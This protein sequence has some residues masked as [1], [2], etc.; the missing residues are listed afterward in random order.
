MRL[1]SLIFS[2]IFFIFFNLS[3]SEFSLEE[4][5]QFLKEGLVSK[6]EYDVLKDEILEIGKYNSAYLYEI[7]INNILKN[8]TFKAEIK[9][10]KVYFPLLDF[11]SIIN[12]VDYE[13]KNRELKAFLGERLLELKINLNN[14]K[15]KLDDKKISFTDEVYM[16]N[17]EIYIESKLFQELLA[18]EFEEDGSRFKIKILLKFKTPYEIKNQ[19]DNRFNRFQEEKNKNILLYTHQKKIFDLGYLRTKLD[20]SYYKKEKKGEWNSSLE[21]QGG[22]LYG[23]LTSSYNLREGELG[24]V[25]INYPEIYKGHSLEVGSY[26]TRNRELGLSLKKEK[27]YFTLGDRIVIREN[28]PIGSRVE[29]LYLGYPLDVKDSEDGIIEFSGSEIR[30][31]R[32][33]SLKVYNPDGTIDLINISTNK[34]Y[35]QQRK[36]EFEFNIDLKEDSRTE[37]F[38]G[39]T[40]IYYGITNNLTLG[41]GIDKYSEEDE[42]RIIEKVKEFNNELIYGDNFKNV[43]Y[44]LVL[45]SNY[46]NLDRKNEY[47]ESEIDFKKVRFRSKIEKFD[48]FYNEKFKQKYTFEYNLSTLQLFYNYYNYKYREKENYFNR[49]SEENYDIGINY[50]IPIKNLL[51]TTDYKIDKTSEQDYSISGYYT[52][53]YLFNTKLTNRWRRNGKEYATAL[54][55]NNKNLASTIDYSLVFDYSNTGEKIVGVKFELDIDDWLK[56][57]VSLPSNRD[58]IYEIGIDKIIDLK[59]IKENIKT[60]DSSRIKVI[61]YLDENNNNIYDKNERR[62]PNN[63]IKIGQKKVTTDENGEAWVYG[64]PNNIL[65]DLNISLQKPSYSTG[66]NTLKVM[67]KRSG[68]IEA[69]IPIKA[70]VNLIGKVKFLGV[71]LK[72]SEEIRLRQDFSIRIKDLN[73]NLIDKLPLEEDGLFI[74]SD[75]YPGN[76]LIE[77]IY[78]GDIYTVNKIEKIVELKYLNGEDMIFDIDL[79]IKK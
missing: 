64:I 79:N 9:D 55:F 25:R 16:E 75:I 76:Y 70:K 14:K 47:F 60:I 22:F 27:G 19:I 1:K 7:T 28:V 48:D 56:F 58:T 44:T 6:E 73:G 35:N 39:N 71:V 11:F 4:I 74:L 51:V 49:G 29:L 15:I 2:N 26:G 54:T 18:E 72:N 69:H 63:N 42:N 17:G 13:I 34:S 30:A 67:G 20:Y 61:T 41:I 66:E 12:L 59:N 31:D 65:Y 10:K 32:E 21:Y 33:Y 45:G 24:D 57:G 78:W 50:N 38:K 8:D 68:T 62:I 5:D 53:Y 3:A 36:G 43:D 37:N 40:N 77:V 23:E 46:I 52:G